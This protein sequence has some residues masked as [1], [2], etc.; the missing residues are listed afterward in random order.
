MTIDRN[1]GSTPSE[2]AVSALPLADR[3][4]LRPREAARALGVSERT[5]R[6]L[7]PQLPHVRLGGVVL[8]PVEALRRWLEEQVKVQESRADAVAREILESLSNAGS[9]RRK[10]TPRATRATG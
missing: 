1:P 7:L 5:L 10:R 9:S 2:V 8:L 3:L 6:S 4:A